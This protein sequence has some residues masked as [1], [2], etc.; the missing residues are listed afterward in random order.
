LR[1]GILEQQREIEAAYFVSKLNT[2]SFGQIGS[3]I[4][5]HAL[6]VLGLVRFTVRAPRGRNGA[7]SA[8]YGYRCRRYRRGIV[9]LVSYV[10]VV[11][12]YNATKVIDKVCFGMIC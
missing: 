9:L 8:F 11:V 10:N 2:V 3:L 12:R 6:R 7:L 4:A 5:F 1:I